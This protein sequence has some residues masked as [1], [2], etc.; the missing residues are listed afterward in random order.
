[1]AATLKVGQTLPFSIRYLDQN[2][3]EMSPTPTTDAPPAWAQN[4]P[5]TE[6]LT[7]APDG[8]TASAIGLA[9][10]IDTIQV[11]LAVGGNSFQATL[12]VT[13]EAVAPSQTLTSIEIV[14]GTP[15]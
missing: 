3:I 2:G 8:L 14:P 9:A 11:T 12:D 15:A 10:G 7:A 4:T 1:M 6:S 5:A 13:V